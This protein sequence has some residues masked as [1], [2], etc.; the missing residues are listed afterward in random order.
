MIKL[1]DAVYS[2]GT[3]WNQSNVSSGYFSGMIVTPTGRILVGYATSGIRYS[4]DNGITWAQTNKTNGAWRSFTS[5]P[6]GRII[7]GGFASGNNDYGIWY[8]DD[9]GIT[10][11]QTNK[12][13]YAWNSLCT[14]AT[15][16]VLAVGPVGGI[17]YSDDNGI[18]WNLTSQT[19]Y[20]W[21]VIF[22]TPTGRILAFSDVDKGVIYSDD[23]GITWA[24]TNQIA[25]SGNKNC[26]C[27]TNTG[28]LFMSFSSSSLP[29]EQQ[30]LCY[31]DDN[32]MTWSKIITSSS[33]S[34]TDPDGICATAFGTIIATDCI[35]DPYQSST[36]YYTKLYYSDDNGE[37][38]TTRTYNN[39]IINGT[40]YQEASIQI[41]NLPRNRVVAMSGNSGIGLIYS[42]IT[43]TTPVV[44]ARE[45]YLDQNGAQEIVTQFKSYCNSLVGGA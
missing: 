22:V 2:I 16:K 32:G 25:G 40:T 44:V 27:I 4:D 29:S 19:D 24:Q 38:W 21:R 7:A 15:G 36:V 20:K 33:D 30:G 41:H 5:T 11:T 3:T 8:S 9:D 18:N 28:R 31:S 37:T 26:Y 34:P 42:D 12:T 13:G 10:W 6:T 35:R 1:K 14:T 23:D 17:W 43:L 45:K 39:G